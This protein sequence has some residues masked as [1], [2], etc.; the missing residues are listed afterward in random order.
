MSQRKVMVGLILVGMLVS[1]T[2]A[3]QPVL[4]MQTEGGQTPAGYPVHYFVFDYLADRTIQPESYQL[5]EMSTPMQSIPDAQLAALIKQPERNQ[6]RLVATVKDRHGITVFRDVV[7]FSPWVRGEFTTGSGEGI[8]G[9]L[10]QAE[11]ASFVVRL[12]YIESGRLILQDSQLVRVAE[13]DLAGLIAHTRHVQPDEYPLAVDARKLSGPP[14]NRVDLVIVGDG[15]T[16]AQEADFMADAQ[17]VASEFFSI[18]PLTEYA[19]YYNLYLLAAASA[20]AGADHPPYE[21]Q[22]EYWDSTCCGDP[23]MLGDPLQGQMV[24]TAFDSRFCANWI[25]RLLVANEGKVMAAVGAAIPDWDQILVIVNDETYGGSGGAIAVVSMN[26]AAVDVAQ[27]EY[28]HSFVNLADEY[29]SPYPGYPPCSDAPG[30]PYGSCEANVTDITLREQIKWLPWILGSTPIPTPETYQYDGLVG[31]F[32][33]ARYQS[34]GMYR[35][36]L[37]CIMRALGEPFCQ[38]PSQEYVLTLYRGGWG[39]PNQGIRLIEPG[40]AQPVTHAICLAQPDEETFSADLLGP[41]GG[42]PIEITWL[43]NGVV[44]PDATSNTYIYTSGDVSVGAHEL[45]LHVKDATTLV[46]PQMDEGELDEGTTWL[47]DIVSPLTMTLSSSAAFIP[48]D[49]AST[50]TITVTLVSELGPM[51]GEVVTFT[52][53]MGEV[54]PITATT[55]FSGT[56]TTVLTSGVLGGTAQV[57]AIHHCK[58]QSIQVEFIAG[59]RFFLPLINKQ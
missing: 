59:S 22:C 15:Y 7:I 25:H 57:S 4:A 5:V 17:N 6:T 48:A 53:T 44:I 45:T 30:S 49:G 52:T 50:A 23:A 12:P 29:E 13:F 40:T 42:P 10:V 36:G 55:D 18:T 47:V 33:G 35:P 19:N 51:S 8:D 41:I 21:A 43:D 28:G 31:L 27:H 14:A 46:N 58:N 34:T 3:P 54:Y 11:R 1:L 37:S 9:H 20:Q 38:V 39:V 32:E 56:A 16:A 24:D 26:Y 2:V